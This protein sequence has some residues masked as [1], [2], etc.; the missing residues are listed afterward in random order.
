MDAANKETMKDQED[1]KEAVA[2]EIGGEGT[3][4]THEARWRGRTL[5]WLS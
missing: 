2:A 5:E 4:L 3:F 1:Q